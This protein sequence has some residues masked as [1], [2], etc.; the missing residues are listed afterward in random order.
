MGNAGNWRLSGRQR[1]RFFG[2]LAFSKK[3]SSSYLKWGKEKDKIYQIS[4]Q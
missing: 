1:E 3:K 4:Q 2:L